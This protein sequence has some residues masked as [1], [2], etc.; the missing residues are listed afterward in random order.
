VFDPEIDRQVLENIDRE[1]LSQTAGMS[2]KGV[3]DGDPV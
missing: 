3:A 1:L 2:M